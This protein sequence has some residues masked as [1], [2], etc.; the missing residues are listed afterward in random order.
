MAFHRCPV[1]MI[2]IKL[3]IRLPADVSLS[4]TGMNRALHAE[5][6]LAAMTL[7]AEF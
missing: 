4:R 6:K 5:H 7:D 2:D 3:K 1:K